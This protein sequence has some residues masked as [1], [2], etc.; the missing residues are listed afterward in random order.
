MITALT[1]S[2]FAMTAQ[3]DT[4]RLSGTSTFAIIQGCVDY[5]EENDLTVAIAIL[6]DR[7]QM[8]GYFRTDNLRQGPAELATKK[9]DYAARWGS[10]TKRLADRVGEG[11]L[12]WALA[13][14]GPPIEGGVP[15][16]SEGGTLLGGV[17]VSGAPAVEDAKCAR[18]GIN[19]AGLRDSRPR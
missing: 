19:K 13:S 8:T 1:V 17:G 3:V 11:S 14:E 4:E 9:A 18:A 2:L 16:Y 6:D 10:D 15:V 7:L 5:A 12:G